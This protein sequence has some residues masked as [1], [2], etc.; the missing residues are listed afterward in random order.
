M[1]ALRIVSALVVVL[2]VVAC[3]GVRQAAQKA[4]TSNDLMQVGLLYHNFWDANKGKGPSG[5]VDLQK[6]AGADPSA[7][8][9]LA[10]VTGGKLVIIWNVRQQDAIKSPGGS[11]SLVLGYESSVPSAGGPVLMADSSVK[12]MTADEFKAAPKAAAGK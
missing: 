8:T 9:A 7:S 1:R 4:K 3:S 5:V 6:L 12:Q 10:E 11:S 2:V